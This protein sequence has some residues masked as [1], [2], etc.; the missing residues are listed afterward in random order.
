MT[1]SALRPRQALDDDVDPAGRYLRHLPDGGNRP[2]GPQIAGL[3]LVFVG[4]LQREEQEPVAAQRA[5]DRVDRHRPVDR[6]RL[7]RERKDDRFTK[8]ERREA[9]SDRYVR[10]LSP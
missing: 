9:R 6:E 10:F 2:D 1:S 4:G 5:V 8:R 7:Q 3:G